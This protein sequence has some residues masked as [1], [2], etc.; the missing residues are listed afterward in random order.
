MSVLLSINR[1]SSDEMRRKFHNIELKPD[2]TN[3]ICAVLHVNS[4]IGGL[5]DTQRYVSV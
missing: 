5:T 4:E 3:S 1:S 2:E